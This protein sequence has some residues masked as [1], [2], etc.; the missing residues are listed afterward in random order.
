MDSLPNSEKEKKPVAQKG[1]KGF[2]P[3]NPGGP[4]RRPLGEM[5]PQDVRQKTS[6]VIG[7]ILHN[8]WEQAEED[9]KKLSAKDRLA[10]TL[11]LTEYYFPKLTRTMVDISPETITAIRGFALIPPVIDITPKDE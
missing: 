10:V 4:G 2:Q 8:L 1:V 6:G 3:G 7:A 11:Q 9:L 5:T